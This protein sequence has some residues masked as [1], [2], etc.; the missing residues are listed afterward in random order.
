MT[1]VGGPELSQGLPG[2]MNLISWQTWKLR[3]AAI[4]SNDAEVQAM[5]EKEDSCFRSRLLWAELNGAGVNRGLVFLAHTVKCV[6]RIKGIVA[7]DSKRGFD[8]ITLQEG[9]MLGLSNV[10][11]AM[12]TLQLKSFFRDNGAVL[13]WLAG[14]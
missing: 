14:D 3:R 13:I 6:Q 5:M 10:R 8:A 2:R 4:S 1:L 12:E 9:P 11:A 7:T